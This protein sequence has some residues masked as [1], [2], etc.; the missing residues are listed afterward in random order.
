MSSH[1][2]R[3]RPCHFPI[4]VPVMASKVLE[5]P[6]E[7]DLVVRIVG[8]VKADTREGDNFLYLCKIVLPEHK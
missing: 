4:V 5:K 1:E 2:E 6:T 7:N 8:V 3:G